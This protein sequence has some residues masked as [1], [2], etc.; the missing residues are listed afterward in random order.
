MSR[1]DSLWVGKAC[2]MRKIIV[3]LSPEHA[4]CEGLA[5]SLL[6]LGFQANF[7]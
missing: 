4:S 1:F 5:S 2:S 6:R 3:G 7:T